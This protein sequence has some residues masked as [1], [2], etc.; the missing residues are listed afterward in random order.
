MVVLFVS[1]KGMNITELC[2]TDVHFFA[3]CKQILIPLQH[4]CNNN[5]SIP[6]NCLYRE[7]YLLVY[8]S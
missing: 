2:Q 6:S 7:I 5:H 4:Y 8:V 1:H 3:F